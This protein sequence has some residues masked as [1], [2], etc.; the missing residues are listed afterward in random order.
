MSLDNMQPVINFHKGSGGL[1]L[2]WAED[3]QGYLSGDL[4]RSACRCAS[5]RAAQS[6]D[7]FNPEAGV[8]VID[9]KPFGVAGLQ[10]FFSD[11]HSR[12]VYPWG[13]LRELTHGS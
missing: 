11:R 5:C 3:D 7:K 8:K 13:Y 1:S 6:Q 4:L 12:G 2:I 9:V 10:L